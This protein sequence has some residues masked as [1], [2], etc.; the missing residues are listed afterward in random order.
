MLLYI[1]RVQNSIIQTSLTILTR[2]R[3]ESSDIES[4]ADKNTA[5][6]IWFKYD[7]I[8]NVKLD[9]NLCWIKQAYGSIKRV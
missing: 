1:I 2:I 5:F 7:I 8:A 9:F 3:S 6:E 4:N